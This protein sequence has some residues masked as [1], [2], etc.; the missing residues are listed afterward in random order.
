MNIRISE[1]LARFTAGAAKLPFFPL[2]NY[3]GSDLPQVNHNIRKVTVSLY[4]R[5]LATVPALNP[6][7]TIV[8]AQRSDADGNTQIW[9]LRVFKRK[10]H[11]LQK[12]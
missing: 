9:G 8:H 10:L 11:L 3:M 4:R 5:K 12:M 6:D 1:W 7:T 2:R